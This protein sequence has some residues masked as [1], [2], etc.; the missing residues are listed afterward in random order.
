MAS[1]NF[2]A[3]QWIKAY[4]TLWYVTPVVNNIKSPKILTHPAK[5]AGDF[6]D[7]HSIKEKYI[8]KWKY[9]CQ[10]YPTQ[11]PSDYR[12]PSCYVLSWHIDIISGWFKSVQFVNASEQNKSW[13]TI[14][15]CWKW[16]QGIVQKVLAFCFCDLVINLTCVCMLHCVSSSTV[17]N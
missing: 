6:L 16:P 17:T 13:V 2:K 7:V 3:V 10:A 8:R 4:N 1:K 14:K 12:T 9:K 15:L 11:L 5:L